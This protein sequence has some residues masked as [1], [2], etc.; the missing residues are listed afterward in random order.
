M[1]LAKLDRQ[2]VESA[3]NANLLIMSSLSGKHQGQTTEDVPH[4]QHDTRLGPCSPLEPLANSGK[5]VII[6]IFI[7]IITTTITV[8]YSAR[9]SPKETSAQSFST[10]KD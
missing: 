1:D 7:I 6:V 4:A 3:L 2:S 9:K 5:M 8:K 10:A